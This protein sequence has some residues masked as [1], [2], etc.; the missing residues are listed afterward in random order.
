MNRYDFYF[1]QLV[2]ETNLDAAF[3]DCESALWSLAQDLGLFGVV[4]GGDLTETSPASLN[5]NSSQPF[6]AYDQLGRRIYYGP[7]QVIDC[8]QDEGG[9]PTVPTNPGKE[10][11]IMLVARSDRNLSDPK[12]DGNGATVYYRREEYFEL[13]VVAGAEA[14]TGLA[15]RPSKPSDAI[16][17]GDVLLSTGDTSIAT[18]DVDITRRD[19]FILSD[20]DRIAVTAGAWTQIAPVTD[21]V[22]AALDSIDGRLI[23]QNSSEQLT[24]D[25]I[26]DAS[27]RDLGDAT[28]PWDL[29]LY[30]LTVDASGRVTGNLVPNTA[31]GQDL[32]STGGR[33]DLYASSLDL[34]GN[35]TITGNLL[36]EAT[37]RDLG[38]AGARWD[39]FAS[40]LNLSGALTMTGD[41]TIT[42][43]VLPEA[44]GR[45]LGSTGARWDLFGSDINLSNKLAASANGVDIGDATNR[46][47]AWLQ[48]VNVYGGITLNSANLNC[49]GNVITNCGGL[50][51]TELILGAG[52]TYER[53]AALSGVS[54]II[55]NAGAWV[56]ETGTVAWTNVGTWWQNV[57][58]DGDLLYIPLVGII[59]NG[60]TITGF[61]MYWYQNVAGSGN[62]HATLYR[63]TATGGGT[64]IGTS[65]GIGGYGSNRTDTKTGLSETVNLATNTYFIAVETS[66]GDTTVRVY[67][68]TIT[69]AITNWMLPIIGGGSAT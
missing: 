50:S 16:V 42:G 21:D 22:Q 34:V 4:S 23:N 8:S 62:V 52:G 66:G 53:S 32:G 65:L 31:S 7:A 35:G 67:N 14:D 41:A 60:V 63:R 39:L 56:Q 43:N 55:D 5:L 48:D 19:L 46:F 68:C 1:R 44:S 13:A 38:S 45:D 58:G 2:S 30:D 61:S 27:G 28:R 47:D 11:W 6:V 26:P 17:L 57:N 12:V 3:D 9:N 10:R 51:T 33:W 59:P 40:S 36:P 49:N 54:I 15:T 20:A 25:L 24:R 37:G 18:G 69:F 29:F 64:N